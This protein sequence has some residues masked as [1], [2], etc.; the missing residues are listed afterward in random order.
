M[1][2]D[3]IVI[4]CIANPYPSDI[5]SFLMG[6]KDMHFTVNLIQMVKFI[7][8]HICYVVPIPTKEP[9]HLEL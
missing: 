8:L 9:S 3:D 7:D 2:E 6:S 4:K 5:S 1:S